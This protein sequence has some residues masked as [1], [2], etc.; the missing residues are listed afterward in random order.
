MKTVSDTNAAALRVD[1]IG[2]TI[3]IN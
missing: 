1:K 2:V 3:K